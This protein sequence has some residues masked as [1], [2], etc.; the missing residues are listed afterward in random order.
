MNVA[1]VGSSSAPAVFCNIVQE[2]APPPNR[3]DN[4]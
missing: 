3:R 2:F 4:F 1:I